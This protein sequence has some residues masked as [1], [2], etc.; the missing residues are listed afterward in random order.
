MIRNKDDFLD[1]LEGLTD[2]LGESGALLPDAYQ[3]T[4]QNAAMDIL[5]HPDMHYVPGYKITELMA[6]MVNIAASVHA[7]GW[8][9]A[10]ESFQ[11]L[12][13]ALGP[14]GII[15]QAFLADAA[16]ERARYEPIML[17]ETYGSPL[18]ERNAILSLRLK[19]LLAAR[20][21]FDPLP[22]S[23]VRSVRMAGNRAIHAECFKIYRIGP[24]LQFFADMIK[25]ADQI[26]ETTYDEF[27]GIAAL[28]ET[29]REDGRLWKLYRH[30]APRFA[31]KAGDPL[32]NDSFTTR[33]N[34]V[35][36]PDT[37]GS[38]TLH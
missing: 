5:S 24:M 7:E 13:E 12:K 32:L 35:Y 15:R 3:N 9:A 18:A 34:M 11:Q 31:A 1:I 20:Q 22:N 28:S 16:M 4:L 2:Q 6:D 38:P 19:R 33:A 36:I 37:P 23:Y 14:D 8:L 29:L 17:A 21:T 26:S 10:D 25:Q 27:E 30:K